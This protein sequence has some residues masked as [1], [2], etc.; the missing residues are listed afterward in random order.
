MFWCSTGV[1]FSAFLISHLHKWYEFRIWGRQ[2]CSICRWYYDSLIWSNLRCVG[3]KCNRT[4]TTCRSGVVI[5][6]LWSTK[7]RRLWWILVMPVISR[8]W[9]RFKPC[10]AGPSFQIHIPICRAFDQNA[11]LDWK[12]FFCKTCVC[13]VEKKILRI[14]AGT[15]RLFDSSHSTY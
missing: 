10:Q 14:L 13:F 15:A 12:T 4:L 8:M 1:D 7:R 6:D 5:I 2:M 3:K 9:V 11:K